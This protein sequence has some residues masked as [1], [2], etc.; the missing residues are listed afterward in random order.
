MKY[1]K[2]NLRTE[3][4]EITYILN[5]VEESE[6]HEIFKNEIEVLSFEEFELTVYEDMAYRMLEIKTVCGN[7]FYEAFATFMNG[8]TRPLIPEFPGESFV[9]TWDFDNFLRPVQHRF[10][11]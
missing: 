9:Y 2:A 11:D 10:F 4:E 1:L 8:Q 7:R 5:F 6:R 3:I